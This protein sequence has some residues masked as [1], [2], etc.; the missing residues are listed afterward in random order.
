MSLG[1]REAKISR[2]TSIGEVGFAG[3][4]GNDSELRAV[5]VALVAGGGRNDSADGSPERQVVA[6]RVYLPDGRRR[7]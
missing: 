7:A 3:G 1:P 5:Q 4:R 6:P 2:G